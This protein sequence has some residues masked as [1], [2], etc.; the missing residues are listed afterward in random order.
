MRKHSQ[1]LFGWSLDELDEEVKRRDGE[2]EVRSRERREV[3]GPSA[4]YLKLLVN[5][6]DGPLWQRAE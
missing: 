6:G 4:P 5:E 1:R 2:S 3:D